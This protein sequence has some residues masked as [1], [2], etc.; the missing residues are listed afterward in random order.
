MR[1]CLPRK[2]NQMKLL[3]MY[4]KYVRKLT[5]AREVDTPLTLTPAD[6]LNAGS[7]SFAYPSESSNQPK[8]TF[9]K[10]VPD[11]NFHYSVATASQ[12]QVELQRHG[13]FTRTREMKQV[14]VGMYRKHVLKIEPDALPSGTSSD[15][16]PTQDVDTLRGKTRAPDSLPP[17]IVD[18]VYYKLSVMQLRKL[19]EP[20]PC[21]VRRLQKHE[22]VAACVQFKP[23]LGKSGHSVLTS[24]GRKRD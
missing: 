2:I 7:W 11:P 17:E 8:Y 14:L 13:F 19:L 1:V 20:H 16:Q 6:T 24:F 18:S 23:A 4:T 15:G 21:V 9:E 10:G 3:T 22:L 5:A 12:L